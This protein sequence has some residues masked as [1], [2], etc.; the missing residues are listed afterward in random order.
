M[1]KWFNSALALVILVVYALFVQSLNIPDG[2]KFF[3]NLMLPVFLGSW[4]IYVIKS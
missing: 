1:S 3:L 4:I 2:Y